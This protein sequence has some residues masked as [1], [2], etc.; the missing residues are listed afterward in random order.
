MGQQ[1][2]ESG[3]HRQFI[4]T[5]PF[6]FQHW[7]MIAEAIVDKC[8]TIQRLPLCYEEVRVQNK[9]VSLN[10]VSSGSILVQLDFSNSIDIGVL[11]A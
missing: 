3:I 5:A 11:Q 6:H 4:E 8:R 1:P 9:L 2:Y 7:K 10:Y